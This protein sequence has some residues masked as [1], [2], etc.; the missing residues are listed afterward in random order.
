MLTRRSLTATASTLLGWSTI[1]LARRCTCPSRPAGA[2]LRGPISR[3]CS[4]DGRESPVS[5]C[6]TIQSFPGGVVVVIMRPPLH[7]VES[8]QRGE[9]SHPESDGLAFK[10]CRAG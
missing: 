5:R 6:S 1:S 9:L 3:D 4:R 8:V 7:D 2:Y 10:Q